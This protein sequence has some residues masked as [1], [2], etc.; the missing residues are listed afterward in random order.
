MTIIPQSLR[1]LMGTIARP[2][3]L[4]TVTLASLVLALAL[5]VAA[6]DG[7]PKTGLEVWDDNAEASG[8]S[9]AV[10]VARS[11]DIV[12]HSGYGLA[13]RELENSFTTDTVFTTGSITKQFTAA[14]ILKLEEQG[15]LSV[16]DPI[17]R[18]FKNVPE[19]KQSITLHHLLTH[20]S[21]L[22][23]DLGGD[24]D[25]ITRE[26]LVEQALASTLQWP[27]GTRY[28]YSNLGYSLL[29]AVIELV[30]GQS[31]ER[32]LS[33]QLFV[34]AGM[35]RTGYRIPEWAP[36]EV[37]VGYREGE[38]WGTPL[39]HVWA[40]DGPW[41]N[42]RANGGLLS[43]LGDLHRWH[44][45]LERDAVLSEESR[46][47]LFK[48]YMPEDEAG[49]SHYGYGWAVFTTVRDTRLVAHDGSNGYFYAD[50]RRYMDEDVLVLF[51]TND[52]RANVPE[53]HLG[54][55]KAVFAD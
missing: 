45:A 44:R 17:N 38:R 8:F 3:E 39:E 24:Y 35:M 25:A 15:K 32:F 37:A 22:I 27:P 41:W 40:E 28:D 55:L 34:P 19:D 6:S 33:E 23:G 21:G 16:V 36:G 9:G 29:G 13:D 2:C 5:P 54:L 47:K 52:L 14:A 20:S 7:S 31:Y 4:A 49:S 10:L 12:L 46:R 48:P 53:F 26:A 42:L 51:V 30:S 43:T 50:F 18:F 1:V 11:G